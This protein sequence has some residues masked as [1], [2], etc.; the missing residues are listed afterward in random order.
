MEGKIYGYIRVS[1]KDQCIDRQLI[2]FAESE[3][4]LTKKHIYIDKISGKDFARPEYKKLMR[5]LKEGDTLVIKSIDRLGRNYEEILE[6]WRIITKEKKAYIVVLDMPLLDTR[7]KKDNLTGTFIADLVLQILSYVAQIE[8]ENIRQRQREGID[9]AMKRGVK[10][11]RPK[12]EKPEEFEKIY[13]LYMEGNISIRGAAKELHV[14]H[15]TFMKWTHERM[16]E[17]GNMEHIR[18]IRRKPEVFDSCE[19]QKSV[20]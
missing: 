10:F 1:S 16:E 15:D 5:K 11:G 12:R 2:A 3:F 19:S 4:H 8:R 6:Q 13:Q 20:V 18:H 14:G 9:A 17:E 7:Q